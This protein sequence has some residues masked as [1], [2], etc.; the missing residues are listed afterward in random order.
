MSTKEQLVARAVHDTG[1]R[2]MLVLREK[3]GREATLTAKGSF[4][5]FFHA[6]DRMLKER[7]FMILLAKNRSRLEVPEDGAGCFR[8]RAD[9]RL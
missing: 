6:P 1:W 4:L 7:R 8:S 2:H 5:L 3:Q 9:V